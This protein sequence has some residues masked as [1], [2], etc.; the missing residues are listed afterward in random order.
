MGV[1]NVTPDSFSDGGRYSAL[2]AA[3]ARG[4]EMADEGADVVD[5]GGESTRPGAVPVPEEEELRR[6]VPVVEALA[7][8]VRV[9][10]DTV[11]PGVARAAVAA[12]ATL[13]NDISGTMWPVAAELSVGWVGM[14]MR[15]TPQ[16]MQ[17]LTDYDDV[18]RE[19]R[20]HLL[21]CADRAA[22]AG[23]PEVWVDPGIGFAKTAAQNLS[24]LS[25]LDALVVDAGRH[26]AR[27]LVGTSR[28]SFLGRV[29]LAAPAPSALA[30]SVL[31]R[32]EPS[33]ATAVWAMAAGVQMVRVHDVAATV[34]AAVL[35][36]A[37]TGGSCG[38]NAASSGAGDGDGNADGN[39]DGIGGS[40]TGPA[41]KRRHSERNPAA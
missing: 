25:C 41:T 33:L 34:Q 36:G 31:D 21:T 22:R 23:V 35:V 18:G 5:V 8:R 40:T 26:G 20:D 6:V 13:L 29:A 3:V 37:P 39:R 1:L 27:V 17:S 30:S 12:G 2:D 15:G 11:K 16:T 19:V 14:H 32:F 9:S 24:L 38:S 10:V 7:G 28:K 4:Q